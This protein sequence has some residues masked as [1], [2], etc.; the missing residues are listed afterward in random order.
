M[1]IDYS[2]EK[3]TGAWTPQEAAHLIR[4]STFENSKSAI[5]TVTSMGLD[6]AIQEIF[7]AKTLEPPLTHLTTD[8]TT[9]QGASWV[10]KPNSLFNAQGRL[11]SMGAW[12]LER[13]RVGGLDISDKM[14]LFWHNHF[15]LNDIADAAYLWSYHSLIREHATGNFR[16]LTRRMTV[17]PAMLRYLNGNENFAQA[18][19][20]NYARELLELFTV[21]KGP[22]VSPGDYTHYNENDIKEIARVLTG[23]VDLPYLSILEAGLPSAQFVWFRH[24]IGNKQL[25]EHFNDRIIT[26][27]ADQEYAVLI[28][29]IFE[30]RACAEFICRK[31][32]RWFVHYD[33]TEEVENQIIQTLASDLIQADYE[34]ESV[35]KKLLS[36]KHFYDLEMRGCL[37]K[38]PY[39][40]IF[41]MMNVFDVENPTDVAERY[42]LN[43]AIYNAGEL[44]EMKYYQVPQVAGWAAYYQAPKY[45]RIWINNVTL[46]YRQILINALF[47]GAVVLESGKKIEIDVLGFVGSMNDPADINILIEDLMLLFYPNRLDDETIQSVKDKLIPG[48]DDFVWGLEYNN[49]LANLN[50]QNVVGQMK[51]RLTELLRYM[52]SLPQYQLV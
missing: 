41:H 42:E 48:L 9:P 25:S 28:N 6:A 37:I 43:F 20:E 12:T 10:N 39:E 2:L 29:I 4:R 34:L 36:S 52:T 17:E 30:Q 11:L 22:Q 38:N 31:L 18:P 46:S 40:Y 1:P 50:D 5:E 15:P 35:L 3:Y 14:V 27:G 16:D 26:N 32:Y 7:T 13:M 47:A 8:P 21:G 49:Y 51:L 23:F 24:D 45:N 33:I 44:M 19:N